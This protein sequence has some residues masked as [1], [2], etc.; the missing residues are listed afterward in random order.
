MDWDEISVS[1]GNSK[2]YILLTPGATFFY[3]NNRFSLNSAVCFPI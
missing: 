2:Q 3:P 1:H